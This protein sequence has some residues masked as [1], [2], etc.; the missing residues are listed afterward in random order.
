M[1]IAA[2]F[3]LS[4][5]THS[6]V[7]ALISWTARYTTVCLDYAEQLKFTLLATIIVWVNKFQAPKILSVLS[8]IACGGNRGGGWGAESWL[9]KSIKWSTEMVESQGPIWGLAVPS[10]S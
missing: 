7:R 1:K 6:V 5:Y 8:S 3:F 4:I 10:L 2:L 9:D